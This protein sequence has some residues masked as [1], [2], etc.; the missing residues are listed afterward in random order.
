MSK[1]NTEQ[2]KDLTLKNIFIMAFY[3]KSNPHYDG[4]FRFMSKTVRF[5]I[6]S[7]FVFLLLVLNL[8]LGLA[9]NKT[10]LIISGFLLLIFIALVIKDIKYAKVLRPIWYGD[11]EGSERLKEEM[12]SKY[13]EELNKKHI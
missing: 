2:E 5:G 1:N 9:V 6:Y 8:I 4:M 7:I 3:P 10:L 11:A 13:F 12:N